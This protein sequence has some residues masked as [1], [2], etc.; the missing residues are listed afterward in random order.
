VVDD[1][2]LETPVFAESGVTAVSFNRGAVATPA[3]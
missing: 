2:T 3:L 1:P